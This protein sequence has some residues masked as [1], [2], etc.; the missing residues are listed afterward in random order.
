MAVRSIEHRETF[1]GQPP[2]LVLAEALA[3]VCL[4]AVLDWW[5]SDTIPLGWLYLVPM[6][7]AATVLGRV[8]LLA[9]AGLCTLLAE[10]FDGYT[11]DWLFGVPRDVLYLSSFAGA[12]LF[13]HG[14]LRNRRAAAAQ[15]RLLE[16]NMAARQDAE[17]QLRV[18][19]EHSPVAVFTANA[20]GAVLLAN[21]A[22]DRIFALERGGLT[23]KSF[24]RFLPP[25]LDFPGLQSGGGAFSTAMQCRGYR[26][27]GEIFQAEVWFSTYTT[28]TGPRL[29][30]FVADG[31]EDLRDR[32]EASLQQLLAGSRVL[33]GA[34][35]HEVRNV[36]GAIA[37]VHENLR[38]SPVLAAEL[39]ASKDFEA[40]GTLVLALER[41]ASVELRGMASQRTA[42]ELGA[43]LEE[44]QIVIAPS[45]RE[46]EI[47]LHWDV[48]PLPPVWADRQ[49]LLQVLLNLV[50]N[51]ERALEPVPDGHA[52]GPER[53]MT[54]QARTEGDR[55]FVTVSDTGPGVARP[56]VLFKPFQQQAHA[57]GLGLYLSRAL[58]RSFSGDL[59]YIPGDRGARFVVD[60]AMAK[61]EAAV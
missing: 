3:L 38:R 10:L 52:P 43:L 33:V 22:A 17:E 18:L 32:E 24:G 49:S 55:V 28:S 6:T 47:A 16:T 19:V 40:L 46:Q 14:M 4:I 8:P 13:M 60:L 53:A 29:A 12:A 59:R 9:L 26:A 57:T 51:S 41:I 54:L 45:L 61:G 15:M 56:E 39:S 31:S 2:A 48:P 23:G 50:K 34:V 20:D 42:V 58:M 11:W 27:N 7:L 37:V 5:V 44:V 30:V 36:C 35:S 1:A 21:E 25:L